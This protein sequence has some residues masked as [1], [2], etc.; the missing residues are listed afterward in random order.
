MDEWSE[1][2]NVA[3][4]EDGERGC[5]TRCVSGTLEGGKGEDMD[6]SLHPRETP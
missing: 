3:G 2:W 6:S 4:L 1:R 5:E